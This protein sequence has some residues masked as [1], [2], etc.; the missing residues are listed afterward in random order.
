[1]HWLDAEMAAKLSQ[2][3]VQRISNA[4]PTAVSHC[5]TGTLA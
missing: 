2:F 1:M 3:C 5:Q 4:Q